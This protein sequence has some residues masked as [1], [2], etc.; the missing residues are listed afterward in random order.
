MPLTEYTTVVALL[1][2]L[3]DAVVEMHATLIA[4]NSKGGK[5]PKVNHAP[6]PVTAVMRVE[7]QRTRSVLAEIERKLLP[8][9]AEP[10]G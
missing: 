6:R 7:K 10:N 8:Q 9:Q 3:V 1:S 2:T 5:R 4:A